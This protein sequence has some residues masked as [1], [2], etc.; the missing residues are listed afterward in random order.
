MT[1]KYTSL[2]AV[3]NA[4]RRGETTL[5][6]LVEY[7]LERIAETRDLNAYVEVFAGEALAKADALDA[8]LRENPAALGR[9]WGMVVSLKDNI[10]YEGHCATAGSKILDGYTALYSA[11]AVARA[12]AEDAIIIGRT[13]CDQFGMGSTNENSVYGPVKNGLAP[14]RVPG[15]SSGGAAVSVQMDTCLAALGS[16]TG[17]SIRQPAAFCGVM[18]FKPTYGRISRYGLI[19]YGSS[20]DQIGVLAH[21][22]SDIALL[23]ETMAGA[24]GF[25][26][27]AE[28]PATE[29]YSENLDFQGKARIAYFPEAIDGEGLEAGV[30]GVTRQFIERLRAQGHAVEPA[31]FDLLDYIIPAYYVLTTAEA[32]SN[33]ARFDGVRYG[34][35]S[36]NARNLEETYLL[37]RT[38]GFS[39]EVKRRILLGTFVLSSGYYD[40]YYSKAQQARR[41]IRDRILE[42]LNDYDFILMP[43]APDVAGR[44]GEKSGDPVA[45]YLS[46]VFTVSANLAGV[47]AIALPAGAHPENGLPVGVQLMGRPWEEGKLLA[48]SHGL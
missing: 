25:D 6:G 32:S 27:T 18:G 14:D 47:P 11:T 21:S 19:A 43:A 39:E 42:I 15:G 44:F 7:Y 8:R 24:D 34:H 35:R 1:P 4:L 5:R 2:D 22:T 33:L 31:S 10:C 37:S 23:L 45:M 17:G 13:N 36:P 20:F 12:L 48:F 3:Q 40:A 46:D 26:S 29:K 41:L 9:L 16:D 38:E 30:R 28:G